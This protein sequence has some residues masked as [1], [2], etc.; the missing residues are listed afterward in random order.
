MGLDAGSL[1]GFFWGTKH[2]T[3]IIIFYYFAASCLSE[4]LYWHWVVSGD[5][6]F[7]FWLDACTWE[8]WLVLLLFISQHLMIFHWVLN[9]CRTLSHF[10]II[11][12]Y[13]FPLVWTFSMCSTLIQQ[14]SFSLLTTKHVPAFSDSYLKP[15]IVCN[16]YISQFTWD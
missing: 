1:F 15:T 11:L 12:L 6:F 8:C 7:F 14:F 13:T 2:N 4:R 10:E 5:Y 16:N 9:T 3:F